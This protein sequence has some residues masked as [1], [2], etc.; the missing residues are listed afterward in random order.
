M[1]HFTWKNT[2]LAD[3]YQTFMKQY[4]FWNSIQDVEKA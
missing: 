4:K 3:P 1:V 2:N